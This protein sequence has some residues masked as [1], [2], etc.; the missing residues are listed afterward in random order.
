MVP[1][2][3]EMD[4]M[5]LGK[6]TVLQNVLMPQLGKSRNKKTRAD[7]DW[8]IVTFQVEPNLRR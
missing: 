8:S 2:L 1:F 7:Q 5:E 4:A 3:M 6:N